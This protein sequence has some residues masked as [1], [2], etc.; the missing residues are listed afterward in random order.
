MRIA[1]EQRPRRQ[2][3]AGLAEAAL[4]R[5][6]HVERALNRVGT[7]RSGEA[8]D[9]ADLPIHTRVRQSQAGQRRFTIYKN[10][11]GSTVAFVTPLFGSGQPR[12]VAD[13]F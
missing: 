13:G 9:R 7:L 3:H 5:A 11:A 4:Q 2:Q 8:F 10:G 12:F 6:T 1:V